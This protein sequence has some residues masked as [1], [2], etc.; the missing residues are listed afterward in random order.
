V[1]ERD[2]PSG[3]IE[4]IPPLVREGIY[5]VKFMHWW[6]GI[7]FG[8]RPKLAIVFRIC[9]QG[10]YFGIELR[11]WYNVKPKGKLGRN[12]EFKAG[13]SSDLVR[14]YANLVGMPRRNDRIAL[15]RYTGLLIN[16]EVK[17]VRET[18]EQQALPEAL[19]YSVIKRLVSI[20]AGKVP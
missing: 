3:E 7:L 2:Q 15:T 18:R 11:R 19:Q 9:D 10:D 8:R 1:K 16:A 5:T 20:E 6:T 14:E 4:N 17:T 12:G 13:W